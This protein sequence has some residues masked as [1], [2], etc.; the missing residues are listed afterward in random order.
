[1]RII[2]K[3]ALFT[4]IAA[5]GGICLG[6][7][8]FPAERTFAG[9]YD[10]SARDITIG[11]SGV[12]QTVNDN[13]DSDPVITGSS[14][15]HSITINTEPDCIVKVKLSELKIDGIR[16]NVLPVRITGI[17]KVIIEIAGDNKLKAGQYFAGI[18]KDGEGFLEIGGTG[19]LDVTGG[20]YGAGIG[21]GRIT[22]TGGTVTATGGIGG[23]GI[24]G[25]HY[26]DAEGI[27]ITGGTVTATG[28]INGAGIGGGGY[29]IC[30][31]ITITGG[32][33]A[34]TGGDSGAGLGG[35]SHR[36]GN[37]IVISGDARVMVAGGKSDDSSGSGAAIGD[38]GL[39]NNVSGNELE[40]RPHLLDS[41]TAFIKYYE[42]GTSTDAMK[43]ATPYKIIS[44]NT[45][46]ITF[47][48]N[49]GSCSIK[50]ATTVPSN[51][52]E[53]LA[54]LPVATRDGYSFDGW[55]TAADGGNEVTT[56]T[57]FD[58]NTT[59]YAHWKKTLD[60]GPDPK[61]NTPKEP[62]ITVSDNK[63]MNVS[64][65]PKGDFK[66]TYAHDIP[67][68]GNSKITPDYFGGIRVSYNDTEYKASSIKV[69]KKKHLIQVTAVEGNDKAI[70]KAIKKATKGKNGLDFKTNPFFVRNT[71]D[72]EIKEKKDGSAKSVKV[73]IN[74]KFY[75]AKKDKEWKYD[76]DT[77]TVTFLGDNLDGS[78]T[79][80]RL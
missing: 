27:T 24:G 1:M 2:R 33:V 46:I 6:L 37:T 19:S 79:R 32:T 5:F 39:D 43:T 15:N 55:F 63:P 26:S 62:P 50:T 67:F 10:I 7:V 38:G 56:S 59:I 40:M 11:F 76:K 53:V 68:F 16:N 54:S 42:P 9:T 8:G 25:G 72:V 20:A 48:A 75:K 31:R 29:G 17:G 70:N 3:I 71:D 41:G 21:G 69:N 13:P 28:G 47:D 57:V 14:I 60:Q 52:S 74:G 77:N 35:G 18:Q 58:S 73:M 22:I 61:P 30:N 36:V 51:G 78:Y 49:G 80:P 34:A 12:Q 44:C 23:A 66:I 64:T 4:L 65:E 45:N